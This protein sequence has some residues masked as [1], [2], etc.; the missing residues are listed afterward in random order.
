MTIGFIGAKAAGKSTAFDYLSRMFSN[1]NE[2]MIAKRLK[3]V[4]SRV[5]LLSEEAFSDPAIKEKRFD[6]PNILTEADVT[7][8]LTQFGLWANPAARDSI[9]SHIGVSLET[10]RAAAQ[11][12]GTQIIRAVDPLAHLRCAEQSFDPDKINII[13]DIRFQNEFDFFKKKYDKFLTY[14]IQ[15]NKAEEIADKDFHAS[16]RERASLS[17][18]C[19]YTLYNNDTF[20][21]FYMQLE[22][23]VHTIYNMGGKFR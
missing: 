12:I 5:L 3:Q 1:L 11:Y 16:E 20:G 10:P 14:Y 4:S 21:L 13:T 17:K 8:I 7:Y 15:N 18:Q 23:M 9:A 2:V 22:P 19:D 6:K